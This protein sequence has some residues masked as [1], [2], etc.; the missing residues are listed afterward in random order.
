MMGKSEEKTGSMV[1]EEEG[2]AM[3]GGEG[4]G[5]MTKKMWAEGRRVEN[6]NC[7]LAGGGDSSVVILIKGVW[8]YWASEVLDGLGWKFKLG[9]GSSWAL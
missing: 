7:G 1:A 3:G 5:R 4:G 9:F 6:L 8:C 2:G